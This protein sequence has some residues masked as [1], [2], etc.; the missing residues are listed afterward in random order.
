MATKKTIIGCNKFNDKSAISN[1]NFTTNL[2]QSLTLNEGDTISVKTSFIDTRN[3][4]AG[5]YTVDKDIEIEME[6]YFYYINRGGN[7]TKSM[8]L[9][10]RTYEPSGKTTINTK[11]QCIACDSNDWEYNA[12]KLADATLYF[13]P[14]VAYPPYY[15]FNN[16]ASNANTDGFGFTIGLYEDVSYDYFIDVFPTLQ[17]ASYKNLTQ[18]PITNDS[19]ATG[20]VQANLNPLLESVYHCYSQVNL[21]NTKSKFTK[22]GVFDQVA[23]GN[24]P[25]G[26]NNVLD[27]NSADGLPY[28][29][30]YYIPE[31]LEKNYVVTPV[32]FT[33]MVIGQT[34]SIIDT[35]L[36]W[37]NRFN[38]SWTYISS[39]LTSPANGLNFVCEETTNNEFSNF[40]D[41]SSFD[42]INQFI[43]NNS[44]GIDFGL[45]GGQSLPENTN[46]VV[47]MY[48]NVVEDKWY[49]F[50]GNITPKFLDGS[51]LSFYKDICG[52]PENEQPNIGDMFIAIAN[53]PPGTSVSVNGNINNVAPGM[54]LQVVSAGLID[55]ELL[56]YVNN[57]PIN[58]DI[59]IINAQVNVN[60]KVISTGNTWGRNNQLRQSSNNASIGDIINLSTPYTPLTISFPML[61]PTQFTTQ[62]NGEYFI[63]Y[64]VGTGSTDWHQYFDVIPG[65]SGF[66]KGNILIA[67]NIT[68]D[69]SSLDNTVQLQWIQLNSINIG[70]TISFNN[71]DEF[72]VV[73]LNLM[74]YEEN[75]TFTTIYKISDHELAEL[76]FN[77][78][79][80]PL[81]GNIL[82]EQPNMLLQNKQIE[83]PFTFTV[84][85]NPS[86]FTDETYNANLLVYDTIQEIV[87][88]TFPLPAFKP[89]S[90]IQGVNN[91]SFNAD[92]VS[93][94]IVGIEN[95]KDT[96]YDNKAMNTG[97]MVPF[98]KT[99][100]FI[101]K[102]GSYS[103]DYLAEILSRA[104][105]KQKA[106]K[107][108]INGKI[109]LST[110][111]K[112]MTEQ[113]IDNNTL[114]AG[115]S[116]KNAA[117]FYGNMNYNQA[118]ILQCKA[119]LVNNDGGT[120]EHYYNS[121]LIHPFLHQ[122]AFPYNVPTQYDSEGDMV[123]VWNKYIPNN[124]FAPK[125]K[126]I[127]PTGQNLDNTTLPI[128]PKYTSN[129]FN[130]NMSLNGDDTPFLYRP[131]AYGTRSDYDP[132]QMSIKLAYNDANYEYLNSTLQK[133]GKNPD[134]SIRV[135]E[136]AYKPLCHDVS[137]P[138]FEN[139]MAT[140][141]E[142]NDIT[143]FK[144]TTDY[145][146]RPV[147]SAAFS[148]IGTTIDGDT[149]P[150]SNV[151]YSNNFKYSFK[152]PTGTRNITS[153]LVGST[154]M[155]LVY[156][157][158]NNGIFSFPYMHTGIYAKA[159]P[160]TS[161]TQE[162][163]G[164][165]SNTSYIPTS[166][167]SGT[168]TIVPTPS[169]IQCES[170]SG[171]IFKNLKAKYV[172]GSGESSFWSDLGFDVDAICLNKEYDDNLQITYDEFISKTSRGFSG[173]ANMYDN[174]SKND[175][176]EVS[177]ISFYDS[178]QIMGF[179]LNP[180]TTTNLST[181]YLA[182]TNN[183]VLF[184]EPI[185]FAVESTEAVNA[186]RTFTNLNDTGHVL[187]SVE[188]YNG[189]LINSETK[190]NIKSIISSY[191]SSANFITNPNSEDIVY[192][193]V[194]EPLDINNLKI[195]LIDPFTGNEV[196]NI[197]PNSSI[198]FSVNQQLQFQNT[199]QKKN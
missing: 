133:F 199:N 173:T 3:K 186:V 43:I 40:T 45:Y 36:P 131:A 93:T 1:S 141:D 4:I 9:G 87:N 58:D 118:S 49:K 34:Y 127:L 164:I 44:F 149:F 52:F 103:P 11:K 20:K 195:V 32:N 75:D 126:N 56:G 148:S 57:N 29:L 25:S 8:Q 178:R 115:V 72:V 13:D 66:N 19:T 90:Q 22:N 151:Q 47:I 41:I 12:K 67:K 193:H 145:S 26:F 140:T 170:Q 180:N 97:K 18:F 137:S 17:H 28:L 143:D 59:N 175:G 154:Q 60:Y 69:M 116:T 15:S 184:N 176:N 191:Y 70:T 190:M 42:T 6:Y 142:L 63:L 65:Q 108:V 171:I 96:N 33:D 188:G 135:I 120:I 147:V 83:T 161:S 81:S 150:I 23:F 77:T 74:G 112:L 197:G 198:Y 31:N 2:K 122:G 163:I 79:D 82:F 117:Q 98:T 110:P 78:D 158:E 92:V 185:Y 54:T 88:Y 157:Q 37:L 85:K 100:K 86:N 71:C 181:Y 48:N 7:N 14:V 68:G 136:M 156:N 102:K 139:I 91:Y 30:H 5:Y 144:V 109:Q 80:P 138:Y 105:S 155:S 162:S 165:Y 152:T 125:N 177:P 166:N 134:G 46:P 51:V 89:T 121:N 160:T 101:L 16:F 183:Y 167:A 130:Y 146:I 64:Q 73:L 39:T 27:V 172:D 84:S 169:V 53:S 196:E 174:V 132:G 119:D 194:G 124:N 153:P 189:S 94:G 179:P 159:D 24:N 95:L 129:D 104:M 55:W 168:V 50:I 106:K 113:L 128:N 38:T 21:D 111:T 192:E 62:Y 123:D 35:G 182:V 10:E 76:N 107:N 61:N 114:Q 99:F 187:L